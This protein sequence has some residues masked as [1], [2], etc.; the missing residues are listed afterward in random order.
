MTRLGNPTFEVNGDPKYRKLH[1]FARTRNAPYFFYYRWFD[2]QER[3]W[4]P[5]EKMQVD[6]PSY[7][8]EDRGHEQNTVRI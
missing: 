1:V 4:Y 3:N 8:L 5:W 7:E 2:N 6:I